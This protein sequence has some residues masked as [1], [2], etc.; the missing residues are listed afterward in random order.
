MN[1]TTTVSSATSATS[2][3][4]A[5]LRYFFDS[6]GG[7]WKVC[8]PDEPGAEAFGPRWTSRPA[9]EEEISGFWS[10]VYD[11]AGVPAPGANLYQETGSLGWHVEEGGW[12]YL[13]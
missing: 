12:T 8:S 2:A 9:T 13:R 1:T 7:L 4:A 10:C 5:R 11:E 6:H 3:S